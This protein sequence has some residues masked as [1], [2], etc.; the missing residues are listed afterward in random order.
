[1][2]SPAHHPP[3]PFPG[4]HLAI[5][6]Q[7]TVRLPR[8][9]SAPEPSSREPPRLDPFLAQR[10][11]QRSTRTAP[12][13]WRQAYLTA[14][15]DILRQRT[16]ACARDPIVTG[17][18]KHSHA[19]ARVYY[20]CASCGA[21]Q[22]AY[23]LGPAP[24]R[25][26]AHLAGITLDAF[27][28]R[29]IHCSGSLLPHAS[30]APPPRSGHTVRQPTRPITGPCPFSSCRVRPHPLVLTTGRTPQQHGARNAGSHLA[31]HF[32][33][34]LSRL[35]P[36]LLPRRRCLTPKA[37]L[38]GLHP[39]ALSKVFS[40]FF[41]SFPLS[42]P[43]HAAE[44]GIRLAL[45]AV[46]SLWQANAQSLAFQAEVSVLGCVCLPSQHTNSKAS[47]KAT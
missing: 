26:A 25:G 1:L 45:S 43:P 29:A 11:A 46:V 36:G 4:G 38:A 16:A 12:L 3:L 32:G 41:F 27:A 20:A 9:S 24:V 14:L 15:G 22:R 47:D 28:R 21:P 30:F 42:L 39:E 44:L 40:L 31:R 13:R 7:A 34:S 17:R 18:A 35:S 23:C 37:I 8:A 6:T 33:R 10:R 19:R 5:A 2:A